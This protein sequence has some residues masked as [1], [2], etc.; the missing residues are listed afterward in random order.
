[1]LDE[2]LYP[3]VPTANWQMLTSERMAL[4]GLLAAFGRGSPSRS[5][6]I[7]AGVSR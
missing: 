7:T 3:N 4:T 5:A 2:V 1:M 6:C